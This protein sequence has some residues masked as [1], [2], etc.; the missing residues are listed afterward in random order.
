MLDWPARRYS[1]YVLV[2]PSLHALLNSKVRA[3]TQAARII[4]VV[5]VTASAF[6]KP[7]LKGNFAIVRLICQVRIVQ[8]L[9]NSG[10][11]RDFSYAKAAKN[12]K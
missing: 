7:P 1:L 2:S 10:Q 8:L 4:L 11:Y 9:N 12:S 3:R 6:Q 5:F